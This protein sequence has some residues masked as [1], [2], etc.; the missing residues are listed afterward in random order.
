MI[1]NMV[2]MERTYMAEVDWNWWE[3][4]KMIVI[5]AR[6]I[7][8]NNIVQSKDTCGQITSKKLQNC[9]QCLGR[10]LQYVCNKESFLCNDCS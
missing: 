2:K 4:A 3:I 1:M 8:P 6:M 10:K 7:L 5:F 9:K